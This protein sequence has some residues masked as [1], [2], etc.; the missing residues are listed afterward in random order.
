MKVNT[1][2]G[3]STDERRFFQKIADVIAE[4]PEIG[5]KF[6]LF[7]VHTHFLINDNEILYETTDFAQRVSTIRPISKENLNHHIEPTQWVISKSGSV[8]VFQACCGAPPPP[9]V[10]ELSH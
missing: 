8:E 9:F 3:L 10:S 6:G 1:L 7:R 2:D 4:N 5:A